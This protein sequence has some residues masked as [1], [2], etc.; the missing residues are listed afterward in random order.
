MTSAQSQLNHREMSS[1]LQV[2]KQP[3]SRCDNIKALTHVD[4]DLPPS[5]IEFAYHIPEFFVVGSY[6]LDESFNQEQESLRALNVKKKTVSW[7]DQVPEDSKDL[8]ENGG[9]GRN[10]FDCIGSVYLGDGVVEIG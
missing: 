4:L 7:T 3:K 10:R 1:R 8:L 5:C 2:A 9:L 6:Y